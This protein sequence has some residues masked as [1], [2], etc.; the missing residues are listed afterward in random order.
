MISQYDQNDDI[1]DEEMSKTITAFDKA[2]QRLP[3]NKR[4]INQYKSLDD[5]KATIS[6]IGD[7]SKTK[8]KQTVKAEG[9][10]LVGTIDGYNVYFITSHAAV[11][12]LGKGTKWCITESDGKHWDNYIYSVKFFFAIR[13]QPL[14][15]ALDKIA[16]VH[17]INNEEEYD[18]EYPNVEV[19]DAEDNSDINAA[20]AELLMFVDKINKTLNN[21]TITSKNQVLTFANG[22]FSGYVNRETDLFWYKDSVLHREDGP[23]IESS[24]GTK[25]WWQNGERHRVNGPAV[26]LSDGTYKWYQNGQLHRKGGPAVQYA[27]GTREWWENNQLHREDGPAVEWPNGTREWWIND[28]RHR[29]DGPAIEKANGIKRWYIANREVTEE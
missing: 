26:E 2:Q 18:E 11:M 10:Q 17:K 14:G 9:A 29:E 12:L 27:D 24:D 7:M 16:I 5:V 28:K 20:S 4:D 13:N 21:Y 15:D 19:F 1:D 6:Q 3:T 8:Q 25:I 22:T 23:A